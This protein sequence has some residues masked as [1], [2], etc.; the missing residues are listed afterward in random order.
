[1]GE[2]HGLF[3]HTRGPK[4]NQEKQQVYGEHSRGEMEDSGRGVPVHFK[5]EKHGGLEKR[6]RFERAPTKK[7][8]GRGKAGKARGRASRLGKKTPQ[9]R[10]R[11]IP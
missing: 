4:R 6:K 5:T 2:S 1:M 3:K 10:G 11:S 7:I 9:N 8:K